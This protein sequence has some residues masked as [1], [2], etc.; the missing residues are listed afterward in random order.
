MRLPKLSI[1][2]FIALLTV[3]A[4][5]S[6]SFYSLTSLPVPKVLAQT[7]SEK[8]AEADRLFQQGIQQL[9]NSQHREALQSLQQALVI[10][11]EIGDRQGEAA[12]LGNLGLA[13][14]FLG[15]YRKV[16]E[17]NQQSLAI[18]R[19]I[20]DRKGEGNALGNLGIAY[21]SLGDY[22]KAIEYQQQSLAIAREIGDRKNEIGALGSLA[23]AYSS[24]ADYQK[25]LDFL[26]QSLAIARE[27]KDP[28]LEQL[29]QELVS[30]VQQRNNPRKVEADR[31]L[32]QGAQQLET[33][34]FREALQPWQ[35]ALAIYREIGD[36][37]REGNVLGNLGNAYYSLGDYR[38]AIEYYQQSLAIFREIGDRQGEGYVLGRLGFVYDALGKYSKAIEYQQQSLAIL[39]EIRDRKGEENGLSNLIK[40]YILLGNYWKAIEYYQ[41]VLTMARE[42]G[43]RQSEGATLGNLG[44][45][46]LFLGDYRKAIEYNQQ[47]IAILQEIGEREKKRIGIAL[48]NLGI[49]YNFLG[50][51]PLAIEY[52]QQSLAIARET[53]DRKGEA[54][55]L[56]NLG[57]FFYKS[58]NLAEAEKTLFQGIEVS[59][60]LRERLGDDDANKVS[61]FEQQANTYRTLQQVLIAQNKT[62]TA[63]EISERGRGRAFVE[64]LTRRLSANPKEII[65]AASLT[66]TIEQIK[67][68]AQKQNATLVQYSII[69]DD[70]KIQGK[71][72]PKESELYIWVIKPTGEVNFRK[73]DLKPLW[74]QQNTSL[75]ELVINTRDSIGVRGRA[76]AI[77]VT[78]P[79][80]NEKQ[81]L[82]KLHELLIKPIADLLPTDPNNHVIFVPQRELF[83]VPF[84]A[85]QDEIGK[86]LIEKHTILT[87]PSIQ[88]LELT[89]AKKAEGQRGRGAGENFGTTL[90]VGNPVMPSLTFKIGEPPEQLSPLPGAQEEAIEIAKF[91]KT[92]PLIGSQAK[93]ATIKSQISQANIIHFATHGLLD[94]G[95]L[96]GKYRAGTPG[97]L[98]FTPD[99]KEDGLLTSDEILDLKLNASL[100]VLSACD[101]G[102][103]QLTGDGV[104]GLSRA[105][106]TAG[107]P[108]IVVSLWAVPDRAT[109]DLMKEFYQQMRTNPNKAQALRQAMLTIMKTRPHPKDWA[110]FTFIGEAF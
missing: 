29:V 88:V 9:R 23:I 89:H 54:E 84:V 50:D 53:G 96:Q 21:Y 103:G 30:K 1:A 77:I 65:P 28:K 92:Q 4:D 71:E 49:A 95:E 18:A 8:K 48:G 10:C 12:V 58:G 25:A 3:V 61:I 97:A 19:E 99:E 107:T 2:T 13:Y 67:Q 6:I 110:A 11:R 80:V 51:Y 76:T 45:T 101:T 104:V 72:Q 108:S 42:I 44:I 20:G 70:F 74:Q 15:D 34:Q 64:L 35:Q 46:Y 47:S 37:K 5:T 78:K 24:L 83:L 14:S 16:I 43:D 98:A 52:Q 90:I 69:P 41:Q 62:T 73:V 38:K 68:I 102:R 7:N 60:S 26:Q 22:R 94:Y 27:L 33:G 82:Q 63:L 40:A 93:E 85:L 75:G 39:R 31:L 86:H 36:L 91:F 17:Y 59:E 109:T 32:Q 66:P 56:N 87:A 57:A 105:F 55:A 79:G 81:R 106:I 100:V